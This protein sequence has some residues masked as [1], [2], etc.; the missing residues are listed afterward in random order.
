MGGGKNKVYLISLVFVSG[1]SLFHA[2]CGTMVGIRSVG[3]GVG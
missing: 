3:V 2:N 1:P